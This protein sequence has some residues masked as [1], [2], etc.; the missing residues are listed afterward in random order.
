[1]NIVEMAASGLPSRPTE[2]SVLWRTVIPGLRAHRL[3]I[4][5]D[6]DRVLISDGW[7]VAFSALRLRALSLRDGQE[8]ASVRLGNAPRALVLETQ[9]RWLAATDTT[10]FRLERTSL[11]VTTKWTTRVPRYSDDLVVGGGHIHTANHA[12]PGLHCIDLETGTAKRRLLDG[13][14]RVHAVGERLIAICGDGGIWSAEFGLPTGSKRNAQAPPV[15]ATATDRNGGLWLSLGQGLLRE[16]NRVSRAEPTPWLGFVGASA[17]N[18]LLSIDLGTPFWDFAVSADARVV[19]IIGA[20]PD[21][22]KNSVV[23]FRTSDYGC[24]HWLKAPVGF[25]IQRVSPDKKLGFAT[26]PLKHDEASAVELICFGL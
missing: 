5:L 26:K 24:E 23:S 3:W 8:L 13:D 18:D 10:L 20:A 16:P 11:K 4:D 6:S 1:M 14:V 12:S 21:G 9:E 19:C 7:G 25:E 15:C 2:A 17:F 22:G